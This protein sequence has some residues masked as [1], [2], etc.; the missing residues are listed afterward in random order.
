LEPGLIY[1]FIYGFVY[2]FTYVFIYVLIYYFFIVFPV[3]VWFCNFMLAPNWTVLYWG[4]ILVLSVFCSCCSVIFYWDI[5][6]LSAVLEI[7]WFV[8]PFCEIV[9]YFY[10]LNYFW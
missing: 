9:V 3:V 2:D 6:G 5:E 7:V 8:V 1:V 10:L 4:V